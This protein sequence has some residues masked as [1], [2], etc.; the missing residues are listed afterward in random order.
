MGQMANG[1]GIEKHAQDP[2][3]E[4]CIHSCSLHLRG[5]RFLWAHLKSQ[6]ISLNIQ[7]VAVGR[8]VRLSVYSACR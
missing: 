6:R 3:L 5:G 2:G 8:R 4:A 1:T 7:S